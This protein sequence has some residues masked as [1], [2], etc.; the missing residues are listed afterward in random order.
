QGSPLLIG[1]ADPGFKMIGM[2]IHDLLHV[3][4]AQDVGKA[5][6]RPVDM[7]GNRGRRN[8]FKRAFPGES[9]VVVG[10]AADEA[11]LVL[12]SVGVGVAVVRTGEIEGFQPMGVRSPAVLADLLMNGVGPPDRLTVFEQSPR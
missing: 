7:G 3:A 8:P 9:P 2:E 1:V 12:P 6:Y 4:S 10:S 11:Q 5:R